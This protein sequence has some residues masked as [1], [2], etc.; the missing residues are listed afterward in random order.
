[1]IYLPEDF[2]NTQ[3]L[4]AKT[5]MYSYGVVILE[6]LTGKTPLELRCL[7]IKLLLSTIL[8]V[9]F[10]LKRS[11]W[12]A[13]SQP[14]LCTKVGWTQANQIGHQIVGWTCCIQLPIVYSNLLENDGELTRL[15]A[16][17]C[18]NYEIEYC[19]CAERGN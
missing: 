17:Q 4:T 15:V 7:V 2:C 18:R 19:M 3:Q 1:M 6:I 10:R 11:T 13:M 12:M 5:D 14:S 8:K 9:C 16:M